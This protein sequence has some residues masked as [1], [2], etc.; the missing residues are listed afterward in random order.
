MKFTI[1]QESR[2]GK[3]RSNQDRLA[4]CYSR[5]ALLLVVADGMGGHLHGEIAA[6]IAVQ[7]ITETFQ[8]E[9]RPTIADEMLFLSRVLSN[10]HHAILD[11]AFDKQLPDPPRT[12]IVACII[13]NS[14]AHWA[15]AGDSRLYLMREGRVAF[16]TRD[17]SRVQVMVDQGLIREG[18]QATHPLRNRIFSCLGGT[19]SPQIEFSRRTPLYAGDTL[20]LC[21]DGVWG[22]P[23][24]DQVLARLDAKNIIQSVPHLMDEAE[25][26]GG[27]TCDNLST[28][29][30]TWL[31][32]FAEAP[33]TTISTMTMPADSFTTK[34]EGFA[35]GQLP[36]AAGDLSDDDIEKA[37]NE[38]NN[39]IRKY[40]K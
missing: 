6:Q 40:S 36:P 11:Y 28:L 25:R 14:L 7:Y 8:R 9:A 4:Y 21:T 35:P 33:P 12:T 16:H 34:M 32:D 26:L 20:L 29:A 17:H 10:A 38:I 24:A 23:G 37:I 1:Y 39:A 18:E 15:H 2:I 31:D 19:H 30:V 3:R 22:P 5:D 27:A 13:Q